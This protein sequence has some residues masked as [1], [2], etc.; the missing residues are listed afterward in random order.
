MKHQ[1]NTH[2][3]CISTVLTTLNAW[4]ARKFVM[5]SDRCKPTKK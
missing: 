4:D 1:F 3:V 2:F 5:A